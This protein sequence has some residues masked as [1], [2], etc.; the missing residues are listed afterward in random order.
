MKTP[1][2]PHNRH[3]L[4]DYIRTAPDGWFVEIREPTRSLQQNAAMWAALTDLSKQVDWYGN[5]LTPDEWKDVLTASLKG[6]K[7]VPGI[8]GGF[9]VLGA[10]TS[11]MTIKEMSDLLEL[12]MAFGAERGV[13][14]SA[15]GYMEAA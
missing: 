3:T 12:A 2:T 14:F 4:M 11:K 9:V 15:P 5:K 8:E 1:L 13:R 6:Q 7:A 10:R